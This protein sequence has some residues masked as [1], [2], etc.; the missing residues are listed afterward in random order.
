[1][2]N[3]L[4]LMAKTRFVL[5]STMQL[6]RF[7]DY[8]IRVLLY[9]CV[10]SDRNPPVTVDELAQ[11]FRIS[12]NHLVKIVH[13]LGQKGY[14][15][16]IRGRGGGIR[17]ARSPSEYRLGELVRELEGG[18]PL[19][20]CANVGCVLNGHCSLVGVFWHTMNV[21][22]EELDKYTLQDALDEDT[23]RAVEAIHPTRELLQSMRQI[24]CATAPSQARGNKK[25][26]DTGIS[27]PANV[28]IHMAD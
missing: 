7:T 4:S 22:Y 14:I 10:D 20:D 12:R 28:K 24:C 9:L 6:T 15:I 5:R 11:Q 17:L 16:T 1:M 8:A 23:A 25:R 3:V 13:L 27:I 18:K 19:I 2:L 26:R 21:F